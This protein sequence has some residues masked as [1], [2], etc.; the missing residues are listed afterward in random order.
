MGRGRGAPLRSL[1]LLGWTVRGPSGGLPWALRIPASCTTG[2]SPG[3]PLP[4]AQ[5]GRFLQVVPQQTG[6]P[7]LSSA[8]CVSPGAQVGLCGALCSPQEHP[9]GQGP[10]HL[11]LQSAPGP[12]HACGHNCNFPP[13]E[14]GKLHPRGRGWWVRGRRRLP[15]QG[16]GATGGWM[17]SAFQAPGEDGGSSGTP[18]PRH[19]PGLPESGRPA[20]QERRPGRGRWQPQLDLFS[21]VPPQSTYATHV[22]P[23]I[24]SGVSYTQ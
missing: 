22:M 2:P 23:L 13:Q 17:A 18:A 10:K 20:W 21:A 3:L 4:R 16:Q 7:S 11:P 12:G 15:L 1:L 5:N 9:R 6:G 19:L 8:R 14:A 24:R